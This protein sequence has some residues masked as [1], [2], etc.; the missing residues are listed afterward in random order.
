MP[1]EQLWMT[2]NFRTDLTLNLEG[3]SKVGS[4]PFKPGDVVV[5]KSGCPKMTVDFFENGMVNCSWFDGKK[6]FSDSFQPETLMPPKPL[7]V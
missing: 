2:V 4:D 3:E 1:A 7:V 5:L 6:R